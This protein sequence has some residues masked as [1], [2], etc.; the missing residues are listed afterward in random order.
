VNS[1]AKRKK[2]AERR[3]KIR[4]LKRELEEF[5]DTNNILTVEE[6]EVLMTVGLR[7]TKPDE[8]C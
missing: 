1:E 6:L 4:S 7:S 2:V 5:L 3:R 8:E